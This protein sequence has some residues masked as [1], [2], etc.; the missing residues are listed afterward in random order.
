MK[1][2]KSRLAI[3]AV[4]AALAL[5]ILAVPA[6]AYF[7]ASDFAR[8]GMPITP[9]KTE[10][11]EHF[12]GGQKVMRFTNDED[13]VPVYVRARISY[14]TDLGLGEQYNPTVE[15]SVND[16]S[17]W[18]NYSKD[19]ENGVEWWYFTR[20]V[21][22]GDATADITA[23]I[24]KWPFM[25]DDVVSAK[26]DATDQGGE[27]SGETKI[28]LTKA[29]G[30]SFNITVVYE[31]VPIPYDDNGEA[32]PLNDNDDAGVIWQTWM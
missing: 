2:N 25:P 14:A 12:S 3:P 5:G 29:D 31:A 4:A 27:T 17:G 13:S 21:E 20:V 24:T 16:G 15:V 30:T 18:Q 10:P 1:L 9:P 23:A 22:P 32:L 11:E 8:G 28:S 6:G 7:T 19:A 26:A